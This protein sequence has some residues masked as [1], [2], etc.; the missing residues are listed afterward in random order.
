MVTPL[1]MTEQEILDFTRNKR[2]DLV[3][4]LAKD[5]APKSKEEQQILLAALDGLDRSALGQM[6]IKSE[7]E[8]ANLGG[9][10]SA[11]IASVLMKIG[12]N[13]PF[14]HARASI[15]FDASIE[16]PVLPDTIPPPEIIDGETHI[17][18]VNLE[19]DQFITQFENK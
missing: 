7:Q 10:A 18:Q 12:T 11:L 16:A 17:G 8:L 4:F 19:Y 14:H 5:G 2:K 15:E 3:D 9:S 13:N 1:L 6:K